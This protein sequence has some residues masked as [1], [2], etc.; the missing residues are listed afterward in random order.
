MDDHSL[1]VVRSRLGRRNSRFSGTTS[2]FHSVQ[3]D[4]Q[5]Y[6]L[7]TMCHSILAKINE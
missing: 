3:E 4:A 2:K 6:N 5:S 1:A 7:L